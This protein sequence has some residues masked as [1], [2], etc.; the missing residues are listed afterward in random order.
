[1]NFELPR[2]RKTQLE[3]LILSLIK[4]ITRFLQPW[5]TIQDWMDLLKQCSFRI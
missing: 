4:M 1:L 2:Q 3:T 5:Q